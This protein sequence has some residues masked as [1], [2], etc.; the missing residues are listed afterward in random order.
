MLKKILVNRHEEVSFELLRKQ[1]EDEQAHVFS[2]VAPKELLPF[3]TSDL[4]NEL[5]DFCWRAH[6]DFVVTDSAFAPLFVVEFD[7][8]SHQSEKQAKRDLKKD[9]LCRIFSLPILHVNSR[10]RDR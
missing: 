3:E 2:K 9:E 4:P 10:Y 8:P 1:A 5:R 6:F 7:G